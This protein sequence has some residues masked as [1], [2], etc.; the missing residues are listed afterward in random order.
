MTRR[1]PT[2]AIIGPDGAGKTT[3]AR[4]LEESLPMPTRYLYMGWNYEA[5]NVMLPFNQ[6]RQRARADGDPPSDSARRRRMPLLHNLAAAL[7]L[8]NLL[9]E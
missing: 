9:A 5:S 2:V 8:A 6:L 4:R 3:I 7:K 1:L